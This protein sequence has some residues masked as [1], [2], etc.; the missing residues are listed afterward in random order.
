MFHFFD[1]IQNTKGDA[2][3]GYYVRAIDTSDG[4]TVSIYADTSLTPIVSV[5]GVADAALGR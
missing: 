5:S 2:L 4:S 1:A 3:I